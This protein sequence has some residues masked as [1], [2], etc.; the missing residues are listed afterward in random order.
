MTEI[1]SEL[2]DVYIASLQRACSLLRFKQEF[3]IEG[4]PIE[5]S[6]EDKCIHNHYLAAF[7]NLLSETLNLMFVLL[8]FS[9][10]VYFGQTLYNITKY[11]GIICLICRFT[12]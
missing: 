8:H 3:Q 7:K 2:L 11:N 4:S 12:I 10:I 5:T 9:N 6:K 1:V